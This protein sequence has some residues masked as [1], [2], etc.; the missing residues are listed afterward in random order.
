MHRDFKPNNFLVTDAAAPIKVAD[1]GQSAILPLGATLTDD[2]GNVHFRAPEVQSGTYSLAADL[3]S[4]GVTLHTMLSGLMPVRDPAGK[5]LPA[6]FGTLGW[7]LQITQCCAECN[8]GPA[9]LHGAVLLTVS[10]LTPL[11]HPTLTPSPCQ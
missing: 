10:P 11:P 4:L 6:T 5:I 7:L 1:F 9:Q 3:W 8:A 2:V